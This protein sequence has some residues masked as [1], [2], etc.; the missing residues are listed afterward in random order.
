MLHAAAGA[1]IRLQLAGEL[2]KH[3]VGVKMKIPAGDLCRG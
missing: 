1:P 3:E 2:L